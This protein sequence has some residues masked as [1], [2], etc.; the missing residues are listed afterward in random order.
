MEQNV[1]DFYKK[2]NVKTN[3]EKCVIKS[4]DFNVTNYKPAYGRIAEHMVLEHNDKIIY[5]VHAPEGC[6]V[7]N[8]NAVHSRMFRDRVVFK[9]VFLPAS[10]LFAKAVTG[11]KFNVRCGYYPKGVD[12]V[13][14]E[15]EKTEDSSIVYLFSV[16]ECCGKGK[17]EIFFRVEDYKGNLFV[18][19]NE[20]QYDYVNKRSKVSLLNALAE[21]FAEKR[22]VLFGEE[23]I[24][25]YEDPVW[26][27]FQAPEGYVI[28][29]STTEK[30]HKDNDA[31]VKH[32]VPIKI[33]EANT[34]YVVF[35]KKTK[36][37][38]AKSKFG[39]VFTLR[40]KH[41]V[42]WKT[43]KGKYVPIYEH[44]KAIYLGSKKDLTTDKEIYILSLP[45]NGIFEHAN[46]TFGY[47]EK[48]VE[49][50]L[51][52][53]QSAVGDI[54][55]YREEVQYREMEKAY[56]KKHGPIDNETRYNRMVGMCCGMRPCMCAPHMMRCGNPVE[57]EM[58]RTM[59]DEMDQFP[60]RRQVKLDSEERE[61]MEREWFGGYS[62]DDPRDGYFTVTR[63]MQIAAP[64]IFTDEK[65]F[66]PIGE[67]YCVIDRPNTKKK[68]KG[69]K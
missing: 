23:S 5:I 69:G 9:P 28:E 2:Y 10:V 31:E 16:S 7:A 26:F 15:K 24:E 48:P 49:S 32:D 57:M 37:I 63:K 62:H 22:S 29:E 43:I 40:G 39:D 20:D 8:E 59:M 34:V 38:Y 54:E 46:V 67:D 66:C 50:R 64:I 18:E 13:F 14:I 53:Y 56:V 36:G 35:T 4:C 3:F 17:R 47:E 55:F 65:G 33:D 42:E 25:A 1:E 45:V 21:A 58:A 30:Y 19:K 41:V 12:I 51:R 61:D 27:R 44:L 11:D 68:N 52:E 60:V 6:R